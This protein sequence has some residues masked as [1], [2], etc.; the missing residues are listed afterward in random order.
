M[1]AIML[2]VANTRGIWVAGSKIRAC[3]GTAIASLTEIVSIW[4]NPG[5]KSYS[6]K[7]SALVLQDRQPGIDV[8]DIHQPIRRDIDVVRLDH[9]RPVRARIDHLLRRWRHEMADL[10]GL[11]RIAD[12]EHPPPGV[13]VGREDQ[14]LGLQGA[15]AVLMKI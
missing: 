11:E 2:A 7:R 9:A 15:G 14:L 8:R 13:L 6:V 5:F 3:A 12:I 1:N 4:R 10:A